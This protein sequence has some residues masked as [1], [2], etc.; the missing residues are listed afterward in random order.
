MR[1]QGAAYLCLQDRAAM[2]CDAR[3][4]F[5]R[6]FPPGYFGFWRGLGA[7]PREGWA[8]ALGRPAPSRPVGS[9]TVTRAAP[10]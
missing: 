7:P 5:S 4:D 3:L 1:V 6:Y 8:Q 9:A 10:R 2:G